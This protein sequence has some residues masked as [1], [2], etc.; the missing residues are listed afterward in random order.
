MAVKNL[1]T[2]AV[3]VANERGVRVAGMECGSMQADG[4]ALAHFLSLPWQSL[5]GPYPIQTGPDAKLVH[6][7][8]ETASA[9]LR[10]GRSATSTT[11]RRGRTRFARTASPSVLSKSTAF[12][13]GRFSKSR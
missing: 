11:V 13:T 9:A 8:A 7:N 10:T 4:N 3:C 1:Q 12:V 6:D 2:L 5:P